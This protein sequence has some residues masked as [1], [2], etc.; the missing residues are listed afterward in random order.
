MDESHDSGRERIL[1][2]NFTW[3]ARRVTLVAL[4]A[5][6]SAGAQMTSPTMSDAT[7]VTRGA[8]RFRGG[9]RWTRIDAVF[10]PDG[11]SA[12]PLGSSLTT[13]LNATTLPLLSSAE[14]TARSMTADPALSLSAGQLTTSADSR[15]ATVPLALEYGL[16]S[17]LSLGLLIPIVQSR[18]VVT[19][20]LNGKSDSSANVG[21]NPSAFFLSTSA[22]NANAGVA[23][24]L[25]SARTQLQARLTFCVLNPASTGCDAVNARSAEADALMAATSAFVLGI[26]NLYGTSASDAPGSPLVP[27]AGSSVQ[28]AI[29][30]KLDS[31]RTDYASFGV[32]AGAGLL[33]A[34]QAAAAN[35]Q[36]NSLV[37]KV[38]YGIE[39]DS[40][41]T[42]QQTA[43]GD[44]ELSATLLLLDTF[45]PGNVTG[46]TARLKVRMAAAGV[47]RLGT[48][49]PARANRPYDVPTGDGQTDF[50]VRGAMDALYR[51]LL[52]TVAGTYT[53][54]TGSIAT[55]RLPNV[56][57]AVF[58]LDFP[59]AG[60]IAY[61]NM[62][63]ARVNPRFMITPA[64]M[65][66]ALAVG[67]W[68]G[69]D[70]VTV[71]GF[72]PAGTP[73]GNQNALTT[74]A[75]GLTLSYSN[76]AS[77][78]GIGGKSFPAEIVF[79]HLETLGASAAGAEKVR[80]DAIELRLYLRA[81]R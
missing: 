57:G 39:L 74:Y 2:S 41:G 38:D 63:S 60:S 26:N 53:V 9:V 68:R 30:A 34:A 15:I 18:T 23:N 73:F 77:S 8:L 25:T 21:P 4:A 50:E 17:R 5:A 79:S 65:V 20:Q 14:V 54:Q 12:L 44:V 31:M 33:A 46:S 19:S 29:D 52:T 47:V 32:T 37:T 71:T 49:H 56:P 80:R 61:G 72:N 67:S 3:L 62:A 13:D 58:G 24:G 66:G 69:A 45:R 16:T 7:V 64:L 22:Y 11:S 35:A 75:G 51:R 55:T 48:G 43:I 6:T 78:E 42:T 1:S 76:L 59:V 81:R 28:A 36:F 40:L 70:Q 10:G 27:I